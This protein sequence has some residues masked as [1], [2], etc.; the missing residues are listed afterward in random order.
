MADVQ[1]TPEQ[2]AEAVRLAEIIGQKVKE[3]TLQIARLL[4]SKPDAEFFGK[5]EFEIRDRVHRIGA[6]AVET[7]LSERKKGATAGQA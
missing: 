1:L 2:E 5:P 4:V 3:E 6:F 7:A